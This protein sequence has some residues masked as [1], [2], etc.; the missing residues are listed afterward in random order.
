[1][2]GLHYIYKKQAIKSETSVVT[3]IQNNGY[4]QQPYLCKSVN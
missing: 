3:V 1:M 4:T 2:K